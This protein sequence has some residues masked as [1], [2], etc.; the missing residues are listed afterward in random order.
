MAEHSP[1]KRTNTGSS[2]VIAVWAGG[3]KGSMLV[4]QTSGLSSS[5]SQSIL[6]NCSS[7][8]DILLV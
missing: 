7:I 2:P 6:L 1:V 5:L 4:L 8:I 3:V